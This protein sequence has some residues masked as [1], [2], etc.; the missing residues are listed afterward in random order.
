MKALGEI[1]TIRSF[2]LAVCS[3]DFFFA[4]FSQNAMLVFSE[5]IFNPS[6]GKKKNLGELMSTVKVS[7]ILNVRKVLA[8][9]P[10]RLARRA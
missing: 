4:E 9:L 7:N 5:F 1:Y 3:D 8:G 10:R 2:A 6:R